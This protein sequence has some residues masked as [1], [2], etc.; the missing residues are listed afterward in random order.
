MQSVSDCAVMT[1]DIS[2][3]RGHPVA[4]SDAVPNVRPAA[5]TFTTV[6]RPLKGHVVRP[7]GRRK[8]IGLCSNGDGCQILKGVQVDR[9][10]LARADVLAAINLEGL[11]DDLFFGAR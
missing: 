4:S 2:M 7:P 3:E 6:V 1:T 10:E 5:R 8:T 11:R 9:L